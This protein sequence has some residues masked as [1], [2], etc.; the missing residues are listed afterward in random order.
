M[1]RE[2]TISREIK[3]LKNKFE[4]LEKN[5][6]FRSILQKSNNANSS[7]GDINEDLASGLDSGKFQQRSRSDAASEADSLQADRRRQS[8]QQ[9]HQARGV[10]NVR[11]KLSRLH[12]V[13][14]IIA[15]LFRFARPTRARRRGNKVS[16]AASGAALAASQMVE[17]DQLGENQQQ[18]ASA[19]GGGGNVADAIGTR[20]GAAKSGLLDRLFKR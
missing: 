1:H 19:S 12:S 9:Q 18:V 8:A 13:G 10:K 15:P 4:L 2:T 17:G 3:L 11:I 16:S 14:Q 6:Q 20:R 5:R 7:L